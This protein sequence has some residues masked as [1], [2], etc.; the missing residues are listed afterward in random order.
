MGENEEGR[1][2][3]LAFHLTPWEG[4]EGEG[5]RNSRGGICHLEK[6]RVYAF[7]LLKE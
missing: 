2:N 6:I 5:K 4:G 1:E 3:L 7:A